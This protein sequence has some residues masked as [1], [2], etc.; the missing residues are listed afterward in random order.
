MV[1]RPAAP[2]AVRPA[3]PSYGEFTPDPGP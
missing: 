3:P 2:V 1:R